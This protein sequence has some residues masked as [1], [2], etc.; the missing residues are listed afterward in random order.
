MMS[1][2]MDLGVKQTTNIQFSI[3]SEKVTGNVIS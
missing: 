3:M 1:T 2:H